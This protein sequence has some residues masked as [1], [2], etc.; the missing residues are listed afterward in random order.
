[1]ARGQTKYAR[2][3]DCVLMLSSRRQGWGFVQQ[4]AVKGWTIIVQYIPSSARADDFS[5]SVCSGYPQYLFVLTLLYCMY[6]RR[7]HLSVCHPTNHKTK[8]PP[9]I[10]AKLCFPNL[11]SNLRLQKTNTRKIL[12]FT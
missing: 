6:V 9:R 10:V 12:R 2:K 7:I 8:I 1:M 5:A 11:R 4:R 3:T